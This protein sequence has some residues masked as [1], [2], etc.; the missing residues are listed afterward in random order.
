MKTIELCQKHT[1]LYKQSVENWMS[2]CDYFRDMY[3]DERRDRERA[4]K[5]AHKHKR[6]ASDYKD[7]LTII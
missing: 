2:M 1:Q 5:L 6:E 3:H 7:L 4:E